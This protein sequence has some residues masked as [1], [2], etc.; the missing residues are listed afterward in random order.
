MSASKREE[1]AGG[2]LYYHP[3]R[4]ICYFQEVYFLFSS[5]LPMPAQ[6]PRPKPGQGGY[7]LLV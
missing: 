5:C 4:K 6:Q 7:G 2:S 3:R 1:K